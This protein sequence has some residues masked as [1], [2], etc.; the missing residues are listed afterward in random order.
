MMCE[1]YSKAGQHQSIKEVVLKKVLG[2][3]GL[4]GLEDGE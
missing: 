2:K 4:P 3:D 1:T